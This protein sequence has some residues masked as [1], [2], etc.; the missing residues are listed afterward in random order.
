MGKCGIRK[1]MRIWSRACAGL[2]SGSCFP[3]RATRPS[4]CSIRTTLRLKHRLWQ[5]IWV[6]LLSLVFRTIAVCQHS[7][8]HLRK[9]QS[10]IFRGRPQHLHKLSTGQ[11]AWTPSPRL[12]LTRL[13]LRFWH[14][15]PWIAPSLCTIFVPRRL[16]RSSSSAWR[17][18]LFL[19]T[20]WRHS[21]LQ[22]PTKITTSTY[23]I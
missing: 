12:R 6:R 5:R 20:L 22:L 8:R 10:T 4:S 19:G 15:Q 7:L 2:P 11:P 3:A 23:L 21:T 16:F 1:R 17:P 9:F 18:T 14:Q 13:R